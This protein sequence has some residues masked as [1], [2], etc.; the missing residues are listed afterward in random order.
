MD[1]KILVKTT[2][3]W[4]NGGVTVKVIDVADIKQVI[5]FA[6]KS[7]RCL[8]QKGGKVTVSGFISTETPIVLPPK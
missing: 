3:M 8:K 7:E 4:T 5:R 2:I 6:K 1:S